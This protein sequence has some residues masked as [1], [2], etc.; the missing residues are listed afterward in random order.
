M[1]AIAQRSW[2]RCAGLLGSKQV[3]CAGPT[4][5]GSGPVYGCG[6]CT[7]RLWPDK[8][9]PTSPPDSSKQGI[10]TKIFKKIPVDHVIT[11][12]AAHE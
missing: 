11:T 2:E 3:R 4:E 5:D 9:A 7:H 6:Q 1:S 8:A 12:T 10:R